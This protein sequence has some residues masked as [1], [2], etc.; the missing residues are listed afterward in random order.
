MGSS[1]ASGVM[2]AF[3]GAV[4]TYTLST[5]ISYAGLLSPVPI[6]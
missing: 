6:N 4:T 3:H 2:R 1:A 5:T